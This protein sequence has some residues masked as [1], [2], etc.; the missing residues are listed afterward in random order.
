MDKDSNKQNIDQNTTGRKILQELEDK[1]K[2]EEV[3][4]YND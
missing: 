1:Y 2:K 4:Y 3:H